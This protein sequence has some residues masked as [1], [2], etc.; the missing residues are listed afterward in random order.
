MQGVLL[1]VVQRRQ[2]APGGQRQEH[3]GQSRV[4]GQHGTV[5]VGADDPSGACPVG[6]GPGPVAVAGHDPAERLR[7]PTPRW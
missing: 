2:D 1:L 6:T 5:H 3:V 4:P 7:P